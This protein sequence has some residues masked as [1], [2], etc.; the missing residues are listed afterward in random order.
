[1]EK[2]ADKDFQVKESGDSIMYVLG[3]YDEKELSDK[4]RSLENN[5]EVQGVVEII[6]NEDVKP[7]ENEQID[8]I[9]NST[10][11]IRDN[12]LATAEII[13]KIWFQ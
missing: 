3:G 5:V 6:E 7:L 11:I 8:K 9:V 12:T 10:E 4:I 1:M 13:K 2:L